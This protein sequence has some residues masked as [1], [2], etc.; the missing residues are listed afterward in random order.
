M[1]RPAP[2]TRTTRLLLAALLLALG[3]GDAF[4]DGHIPA[5]QF[6]DEDAPSAAEVWESQQEWSYS[7]YYLIPLLRHRDE[8][9]KGGAWPWLMLDPVYDLIRVPERV[10]PYPLYPVAAVFDLLHLP[11]GAIAGL[12]GD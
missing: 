8:A 2:S 10:R 4:A 5:E 9:G 3:T 1:T 12:F 6:V 11:I 7:T